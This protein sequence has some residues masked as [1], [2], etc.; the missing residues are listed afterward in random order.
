MNDII[1]KCKEAILIEIA[2]E[3]REEAIGIIELT[4][5]DIR[6]EFLDRHNKD[7]GNICCLILD[8]AKITLIKEGKLTAKNSDGFG[9]PFI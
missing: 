4:T 6:N 9:K 5:D 2:E 3:Y 7:D 1:E 8:Y